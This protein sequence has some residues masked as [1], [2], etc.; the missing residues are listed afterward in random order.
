MVFVFPFSLSRHKSVNSQGSGVYLPAPI[1]R[2]TVLTGMRHSRQTNSFWESSGR[3]C[4]VSSKQPT[5][6][7]SCCCITG[8]WC[9]WWGFCLHTSMRWFFSPHILLVILFY[10][11]IIP[12]QFKGMVFVSQEKGALIVW[13]LPLHLCTFVTYHPFVNES[14]WLL[15]LT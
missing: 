2:V 6:V 13:S 1:L 3:S 4:S 14:K 10:C 15:F 9:S 11:P 8:C 5:S 7:C 12:I